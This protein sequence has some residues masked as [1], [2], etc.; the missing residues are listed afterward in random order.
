MP[1][2]ALR[3]ITAVVTETAVIDPAWRNMPRS[4]AIAAT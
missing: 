1:G 2:F 4:P 3:A